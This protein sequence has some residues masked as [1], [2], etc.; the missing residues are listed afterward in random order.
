MN[1][2]GLTPWSVACAVMRSSVTASVTDVTM[3]TQL[4]LP[5]CAFRLRS[6]T[7]RVRT[8]PMITAP[9]SEAVAAELR[10][11]SARKRYTVRSIADRLEPTE[12]SMWVSRR[13]R[14][15]TLS[16]DDVERISAALEVDPL[17]VLQAARPAGTA[18]TP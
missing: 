6:L 8:V 13:L 15:V 14:G 4:F 16:V 2:D 17:D 18:A 1:R 9:L 3:G 12:N 5:K 10:A 7:I 11:I